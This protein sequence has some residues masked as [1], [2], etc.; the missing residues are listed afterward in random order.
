MRPIDDP[1]ELSPNERLDELAAILAAGLLR[2]REQPERSAKNGRFPASVVQ[3]PSH[4]ALN[5]WRPRG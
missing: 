1:S 4:R 3:T 5:L 2:L